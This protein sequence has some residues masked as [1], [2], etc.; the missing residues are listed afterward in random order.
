LNTLE[1]TIIAA[2]ICYFL[3][4][5]F[6]S[7]FFRNKKSESSFI[8]ADRNLGSIPITSSLAASFRDGS[9]IV[10]WVGFGFTIG[11]GSLWIMF[12][13]LLGLCVYIGFGPKMRQASIEHNAITV[14]ELIRSA[15]GPVTEKFSAGLVLVFTLV[16]IAVQLYVAGHLFSILLNLEL[17]I[18]MSIVA[19]VAGLYLI[20][21]GFSAVI[22]TDIIQFVLVFSV[23]CIPLTSSTSSQQLLDMSSLF[24][25]PVIDQFALFL[26]G[27][28]FV[29]SSTDVWQKIFS[30]RNDTVIK[31]SF[32][33]AG[34]LLIVMTISLIWLGITAKTLLSGE[35]SSGQVIFEFF[36]QAALTTPMLALLAVVIMAIT[37]STLDTFCYLFSSSLLKNFL[38]NKS[39]DRPTQYIKN[40]RMILLLVLFT[41]SIMA[42]LI[43]DVIQTILSAASLLFILAPVYISLGFGWLKNSPEYDRMVGFSM[44]ISVVVYIV[45]LLR[46]DLEQMILL[47]VPVFVNTGL[48]F[49]L[50]MY[51]RVREY[52][53]A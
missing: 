11:F 39:S 41:G 46:G 48:L 12:G 47:S 28:F 22:K 10:A 13:A 29:L 23:I 16:I 14:G 36:N 32:S 1:L 38:N 15:L 40:S 42:L 4:I 9:G 7:I 5:L 3:L 27:F 33:L 53:V 50:F 51:A 34:A 19:I 35:I 30:A 44:L 45:M 8:I 43:Y 49:M 24:S 31:N 6:V 52:K 20:S 17:W 37:M 2:I 25:F 26:L 18:G 21:G